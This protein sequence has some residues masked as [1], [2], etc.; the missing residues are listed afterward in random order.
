MPMLRL[1]AVLAAALFSAG[2]AAQQPPAAA[3]PSAAAV[4]RMPRLERI[5]ATNQ[6]VIG[7]RESAVPFAFHGRDGE[8]VG[9]GV[10]IAAAI[11]QAV[12]ERLQRPAL[13]VR[14]NAVTPVTL[15]PLMVNGVI[16]IECGSTTNTPSRQKVVA[17]S[18]TI[19]VSVVRIGV[20]AGSTVAGLDDLGGRR[21]T[22]AA[23][24]TTDRRVR[25]IDAERKL[26][27]K[28]V[29]AR[30]N[31]R[32]FQALERGD[33]DAFVAGQALLAGEFVRAGRR[34]AFK[35][36]G[37]PIEREAF[38]CVLPKDDPAFKRVVDDAIARLMS[39]GEFAR[40]YD[41]WFMQPLSR[42]VG[43]I[44]LPMSAELKAL[45]AAPND[46]PIE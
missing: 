21:V 14:H 20:P 46:L 30:N 29:P 44:G 9:Y 43:A 6:M 5:A 15:V 16:D 37:E 27:M 8:A 10:D 40:I 23:D 39:S 13:N 19:F 3:A 24:T 7:F 2:A 33:A 31:L 34:D 17:F 38:G 35:V 28:I 26:G 41:R 4:S 1:L 12:K 22:V 42:D 36:V 45:V 18:N 11:A 32:A 25:A